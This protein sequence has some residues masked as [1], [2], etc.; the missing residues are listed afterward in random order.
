MLPRMAETQ[1]APLRPLLL[2]LGLKP[3]FLQVVPRQS[4]CPWAL[5]MA[6]C[7]GAVCTQPPCQSGGNSSCLQSLTSP[8][9]PGLATGNRAA[10][11]ALGTGPSGPVDQQK[12]PPP[13]TPTC[14]CLGVVF[15]SMGSAAQEQ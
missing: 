1:G 5:H 13:P 4:S 7:L 15:P 2:S 9:A 12:Q 14:S 3:H 8:T 6:T 11:R 10:L